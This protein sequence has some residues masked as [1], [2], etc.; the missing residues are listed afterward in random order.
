MTTKSRIRDLED[1]VSRIEAAATPAEGQLQ[2]WLEK[3]EAS[4]TA[5]WAEEMSALNDMRTQLNR[6]LAFQD[7]RLASL[8]LK[9]DMTHSRVERADRI[10]DE[11]RQAQEEH[12]ATLGE[13][14]DR[15]ECRSSSLQSATITTPEAV[16]V[17]DRHPASLP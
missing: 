12:Q 4:I 10:Q 7:D 9:L 16:A 6:Q 2:S 15:L 8:G 3:I 11:V 13:I 17:A 5:T 14:A 1:R